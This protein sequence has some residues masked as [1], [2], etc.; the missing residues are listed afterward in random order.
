MS[1]GLA[2]ASRWYNEVHLGC[3]IVIPL[4]GT[5]QGVLREGCHGGLACSAQPCRRAPGISACINEE[6]NQSRFCTCKYQELL[7]W[8]PIACSW[9]RARVLDADLSWEHW[10]R[11]R[12]CVSATCKW[13]RQ[14]PSSIGTRQ[15][16]H[17]CLRGTNTFNGGRESRL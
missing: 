17:M 4:R 11:W 3:G 12:N 14:D 15:H 2:M 8:I 5:P 13:P 9:G 7:G 6:M 1:Q 16:Y 10:S